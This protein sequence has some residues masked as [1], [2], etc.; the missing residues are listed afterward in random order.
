M[1]KKRQRNSDMN[2]SL[3]VVGAMASTVVLVAALVGVTLVRPV[4]SVADHTSGPTSMVRQTVSPTRLEY[5]CPARMA[6]PDAESYGDSQFQASV[7]DITAA[8]RYAA[9]GDVYAVSSA[10]LAQTTSG[11]Q[12]QRDPAD[13]SAALVADVNISDQSRMLI[14]RI[15]QAAT[16]TGVAATSASWASQ[17]DLRGVAASSCVM[18][19][20]SHAF[21]LNGTDTGTT[22]QL[23]VSNPSDKPTTLHVRGWA[24]SSPG[25]RTL[26]T[27]ATITVSAHG[28]TTMNLSAALP[29]EQGAY[30]TITSDQTPVAAVVR[31]VRSQGLTPLGSEFVTATSAKRGVSVMPGVRES[32]AV[33]IRLFAKRAT[34]VR[35]SWVGD[36]GQRHIDDVHVPAGQVVVLDAA[37]APSGTLGV[38]VDG[39]DTAVSADA[40]LTRSGDSGQQDFAVVQTAQVAASS[41]LSVPEGLNAQLTMINT[42]DSDTQVAIEGYTAQGKLVGTTTVDIAASA[43]L[44]VPMD[45]QLRDAVVFRLKDKHAAVAW[46]LRLGSSMVDNAHMAGLATVNPTVLTKVRTQVSASRDPAIVR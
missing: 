13:M 14:A 16:G 18:P 2:G 28:E 40:V 24:S 35:V 19:A 37:T 3:R 46:N 41:G 29:D 12:Q 31:M 36:F 9:F 11:E 7:G 32:D 33:T 1:S 34:S 5:Y 38:I 15:M 17:G 27:G 23:V 42:T 43:A 25:E 6:L 4:S 44:A 21:I 30:V 45:A 22:Q 20:M 39:G 26:S 10:A 8:A